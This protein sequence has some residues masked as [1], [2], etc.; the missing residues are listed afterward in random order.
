MTIEISWLEEKIFFDTINPP[1]STIIEDVVKEKHFAKGDIIIEQDSAGGTL[2]LLRS[3]SVSIHCN[4]VLLASAGE[5]KLFGEISFLT[6]DGTSASVIAES[7]CVI[8]TLTREGYAQLIRENTNMVFALF[9][10]ILKN[11]G[12]VIRKMNADH[13]VMQHYIM[14]GRA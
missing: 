9:A 1:C 8:Y 14:G 2:Y 7:D 10:Y 6:G 4:G 3:G 11:S 5:A 12:N 13:S